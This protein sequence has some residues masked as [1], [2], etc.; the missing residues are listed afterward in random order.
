MLRILPFFATASVT[1]FI[2]SVAAAEN[3]LPNLFVFIADDHGHL[4][5][6]DAGASEFRTPTL[7]R[8]AQD[9]I[10]FTHA[11]TASPSCAPSRAAFL[12]GLMPVRNGSMLNHQPPRGEVKKLPAFLQPLGYEV[13]AF[14]KVA[15]YKQAHLY[16]FDFSAHDTFHDD[17]CIPAAIE[18]LKQRKS[19]KPLCLFVGTNW[20]HVPWPEPS[21]ASAARAADSFP[22]PAAHVDTSATRRWRA[23]YVAAVERF[24]RDLALVYDEA[25]KRLGRNTLFIQFSDNGAQWPFAKWNLY[26]AG[27]RTSLHA[28]WPGVIQPGS[29]SAALVSL[30]DLLP[31]LVAAAG[32]A[33][34]TDIDGRSFLQLVTGHDAEFRDAVFTTHSGDGK[35]NEYPMRAVR[36]TRWKYIRNLKPEAEFHTHIDLGKPVDGNEYWASWVE[37]AKTDA[38]AAGLVRRYGHRPAEELYDL[39]ADPFEEQNLANDNGHAQ[40]L[41]E[42]RT[43]LENWMHTQDDA[44]L[45]TEQRAAKSFPNALPP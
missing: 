23:R 28:V 44:G 13:V 43:R 14:G 35:M 9:G 7:N 18:F 30:V 24:D 20:P 40:I 5:S 8:L 16:D 39:D 41:R 36:T 4:D 31:T 45:A 15:H 10:T 1:L 19:T 22:P 29:R 25:Y 33:P 12:T 37:R 38:A 2:I 21:S 17:E 34:P 42:L 11:F 6:S 3:S 26:D 32:G 27:T